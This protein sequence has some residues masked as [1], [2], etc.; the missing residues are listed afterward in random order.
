MYSSLINQSVCS[1]SSLIN[2]IAVSNLIKAGPFQEGIVNR[3][4][5]L[6]NVTGNAVV[7]SYWMAERLVPLP[8]LEVSRVRSQARPTISVK[9]MALLCKL[10]SGTRSQALQLRL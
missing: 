4:L 7:M 9:K 8:A 6:T 1:E 5:V 2:Q 3:A 10:A